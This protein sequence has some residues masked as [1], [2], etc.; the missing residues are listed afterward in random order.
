MSFIGFLIYPQPPP[1]E[2]KSDF[3]TT[4]VETESQVQGLSLSGPIY[5]PQKTNM[6]PEN[7]GPLEK[8]I[9]IGNHQF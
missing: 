5:T 7:V 1:W 4:K 8:E 3:L 6:A 2:K 9:P